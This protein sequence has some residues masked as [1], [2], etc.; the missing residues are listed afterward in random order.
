MYSLWRMTMPHCA[1]SHPS[2]PEI[3]CD[4]DIPCFGLHAN[5]PEK[6]S[7]PGNPL[8]PQPTRTKTGRAA[9]KAQL[10]LM[11]QRASR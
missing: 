11:S 9:L 8:P 2:R 3:L 4:K 6:E 10:A 5:A 7:W 1:A